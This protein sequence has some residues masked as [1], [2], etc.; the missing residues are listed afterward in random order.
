VYTIT[1]RRSAVCELL[2][3]GGAHLLSVAV[4]AGQVDADALV[5]SVNVG[6]WGQERA[7]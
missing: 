1:S 5:D 7:G 4:Q 6:A 3:L 2:L